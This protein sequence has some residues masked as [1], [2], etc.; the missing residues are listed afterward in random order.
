MHISVGAMDAHTQILFYG[1]C[2]GPFLVLMAVAYREH[3]RSSR[4][5]MPEPSVPHDTDRYLAPELR[6]A[7][8]AR[9]GP[10]A[11]SRPDDEGEESGRS[12]GVQPPA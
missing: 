4:A 3:R 10:R 5:D 7:R 6:R 11:E 1:M 12:A 9:P 8:A 2:F